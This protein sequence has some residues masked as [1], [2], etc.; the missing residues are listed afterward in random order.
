M[1]I[2]EISLNVRKK[3]FAV[4]VIKHWSRLYKKIVDSP[5]LKILKI[6]VDMFLGKLTPTDLA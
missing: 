3:I 2:Q 6:Q 1:E 5:F 4:N